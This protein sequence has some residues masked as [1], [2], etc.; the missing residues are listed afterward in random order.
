MADLPVICPE[1]GDDEVCEGLRLCSDC[2]EKVCYTCGALLRGG[3]CVECS[4][5][6]AHGG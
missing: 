6:V 3:L 1:C 5:T 2:L 4:V